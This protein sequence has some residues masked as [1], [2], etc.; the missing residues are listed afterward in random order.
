MVERLLELER[1][2]NYD[3]IFKQV[4]DI[5]PCDCDFSL[6]ADSAIITP[7]GKSSIHFSHLEKLAEVFGS[8]SISIRK[9]A[10]RNDCLIR[11]KICN[12]KV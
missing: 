3:E 1:I 10:W 2:V 11:I 5:M 4:L 6:Y 8:K 12:I 9:P 7:L